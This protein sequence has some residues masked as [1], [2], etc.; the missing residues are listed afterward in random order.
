MTARN[1]PESFS[2][3]RPRRRTRSRARPPRTV[4]VRPSGTPTATPPGGRCN[5]DTGDVA[6]DH[7][8][9][10][11]QD[12]GPHRRRWGWTPT[13]SRSPGPGCSRAAP[14]RFNQ[15]GLDFYS[16]LVDGLL[17]RGIRPVATLYHWDL[18][19][20]LEDAGGW[21][22]RETALRFAGVRAGDRR[23]RSATGCTPGPRSTSRGARRT[24]AT[25]SG[26]ARARPHRAGGRAGRGAPPEPRARPGRPGGAASSAPSRRAVGDAEPARRP[27]ARPTRPPTATRS[28]GSTRWP[29][30]PS[31]ARCSTA[32]T[33]PTCSPTPPP[34]PTGRSSQDGDRG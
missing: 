19:Q 8:H 27:A 9:R 11:P 24:W 31:S 17:E 22:A 16:R 6:A 12:L 33:R 18:P 20:E 1:F 14:G 32:R 34:S 13:G 23:R 7:Y 2:G 29:T 4:A 10:W 3:G 26:R 21:P 25:R 30:G 28:G 5:G 15:A